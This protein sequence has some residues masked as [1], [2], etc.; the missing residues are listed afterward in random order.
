LGQP[1]GTSGLQI[2][3][4]NGHT[5]LLFGGDKISLL[6]VS[7]SQFRPSDVSFL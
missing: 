5:A 2:T 4:E 6:G 1:F 3:N 7:T